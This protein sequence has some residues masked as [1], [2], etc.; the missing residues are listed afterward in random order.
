MAMLGMSGYDLA[1]RFVIG[2]ATASLSRVTGMARSDRR[3]W[4]GFDRYLTSWWGGEAGV[5]EVESG[6]VNGARMKMRIK[7]GLS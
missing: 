7:D 3:A 4:P 6:A 1:R 2:T 5:T